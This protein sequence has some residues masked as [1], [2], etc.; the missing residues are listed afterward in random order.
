MIRRDALGAVPFLRGR[1]LEPFTITCATCKAR[2]KVR[3]RSAIGQIVACPKCRSMVMV[4]SPHGSPLLGGG[5]QDPSRTTEAS[6]AKVRPPSR[7][8]DSQENTVSG[9]HDDLTPSRLMAESPPTAAGRSNADTLPELESEPL[10]N[11]LPPSVGFASPPAPVSAASPMPPGPSSA[12][13]APQV[14]RFRQ[15]MMVAGA[16]MLGSLL[17]ILVFGYLGNRWGQ[18]PITASNPSSDGRGK[19]SDDAGSRLPGPPY[20]GSADGKDAAPIGVAER[21]ITG[22]GTDD[23]NAE[24]RGEADVPSE[25]G[26]DGSGVEPARNPPVATEVPVPERGNDTEPIPEATGDRAARPVPKGQPGEVSPFGEFSDIFQSRTGQGNPPR[27]LPERPRT[28]GQGSRPDGAEQSALPRPEPR[29]IDLEARLADRLV[30]YRQESIPLAEFASFMTQWSTIPLVFDWDA[31]RLRH[32]SVDASLTIHAPQQ[33][34]VGRLLDAVL[35]PHH[36]GLRTEGEVVAIT[37][38]EEWRTEAKVERISLDDLLS[39]TAAEADAV[40]EWI[41]IFAAPQSWDDQGGDGTLA[42]ENRQL[43][44][45]NVPAVIAE[46][47]FLCDR[48]RAARGLKGLHYSNEEVALFHTPWQDNARLAAPVTL[49]YVRP[50]RW[51]EILKRLSADTQ[52]TIVVDWRGVAEAGWN[53]AATIKFTTDGK[54]LQEA[55]QAMVVPMELSYR[56]VDRNTIVISSA[57]TL[58]EQL[59]VDVFP[60]HSLRDAGDDADQILERVRMAVDPLQL[61]ENGG[62][63]EI[64]VEANGLYLWARLSYAPMQVI[65]ELLAPRA[66]SKSDPLE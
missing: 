20:S 10:G 52:T 34:T 21:P 25:R 60:L 31:L 41:K 55:I 24:T 33:T 49:N 56:V 58:S 19:T 27:G 23:A 14:R 36:L 9:S 15:I 2:L 32:I 57:R 64:V 18:P 40:L 48:M 17:A 38:S 6:A 50:T 63:G 44:I 3:D 59:F 35:K 16:A 66:S 11:S 42:I 26:P 37:F 30:S 62:S 12:F 5:S 39:A 8:F 47:V 28:A 53:P 61:R 4:E 43:V 1:T 7:P 46:V 22:G 54:P 65:A 29:E 13:D 51:S 45:N